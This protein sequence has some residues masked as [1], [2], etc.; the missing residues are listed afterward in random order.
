MSARVTSKKLARS[1]AEADLICEI[2]SIDSTRLTAAFRARLQA[3][4]G[5][6]ARE[7]ESALLARGAR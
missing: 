1:I 6:F 4:L 3:I 7:A 2:L 5:T